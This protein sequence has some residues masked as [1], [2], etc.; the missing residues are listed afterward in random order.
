M[1]TEKDKAQKK[2]AKLMEKTIQAAQTALD[3]KVIKA[4]NA[5]D[6]NGDAYET[7][8][9][10]MDAYGWEIISES[11]K[12]R[13]LKALEYKKDRPHL[14][15]DYL[16]SLCRRALY[17]IDNDNYAEEKERKDRDIQNKIAEI[18]RNGG[19]PLSCGCCGI[20][21]GELDLNGKRRE[22]PEYTECSRGRVCTDCLR[23]C[24]NQCKVR[25][26]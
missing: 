23:N 3:Q 5:V 2:F 9:D 13:L 20:I 14:M 18:Q 16:I 6:H 11:E 26:N 19:V 1:T 4:M 10:V 12:D 17:L 25:D 8:I 24:R 15:E 7:E 22:Y 21:V